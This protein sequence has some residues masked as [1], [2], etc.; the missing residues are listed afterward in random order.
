M[1]ISHKYKFIFIA[2]PKSA[3]QYIRRMF[4]PYLGSKDQE[5]CAL[6]ERLKSDQYPQLNGVGHISAKRIKEAVGDKIWNTYYKFAFIR[7]PYERIVSIFSFRRRKYMKSLEAKGDTQLINKIY[8]NKP[9]ASMYYT[10]GIQRF[11]KHTQSHWIYD[12]EDNLMID[13]IGSMNSLHEDLKFIFNKVGLPEYNE[14]DKINDSRII[15]NYTSYYDKTFNSLIAND[16]KQDIKNLSSFNFYSQNTLNYLKSQTNN[17]W[18]KKEHI[19]HQNFSLTGININSIKVE[20]SNIEEQ[21]KYLKPEKT[22]F[23][24][25]NTVKNICFIQKNLNRNSIEDSNISH[26]TLYNNMITLIEKYISS[27]VP[28]KCSI[29]K[30]SYIELNDKYKFSYIFRNRYRFPDYHYT[31][32][33][34]LNKIEVKRNNRRLLEN[35]DNN[36][37]P[38]TLNPGNLFFVNSIKKIYFEYPNNT[39]LLF[40]KLLSNK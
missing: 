34:P 27:L 20:I 16:F 15:K 7:D 17:Y 4:R 40:I 38:I 23:D 25:T 19:N 37:Y 36:N 14:K 24:M 26:N 6:F 12:D 29:L 13:Y 31:L 1:I 8:E 32:I 10:G 21:L 39:K 3:S 35:E 30:A 33:I 11:F 22:R 5:I 2:I 9:F 18:M 28:F